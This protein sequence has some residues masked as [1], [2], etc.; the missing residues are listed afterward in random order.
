M[1]YIDD[2]R[3][4]LRA[5]KA[6][7]VIRGDKIVFDKEQL[8]L[9]LALED[10]EVEVTARIL[11]SIMD[12][13]V[14]GIRFT[15]ETYLDFKQNWGLPTLDSMLKVVK[16]EVGK[17]KIGYMFY[18][19]E[20]ST[21]LVTPYRSAQPINGKICSLSQDV[22]RVMSNSNY[23]VTMDEKIAMLDNFCARMEA[24]G[25]PPKIAAQVVRNGLLCYEKK[26]RK[27]KATGK[28]FH[29]PEEEGKLERRIGKL[30][31]RSNWF[32]PEKKKEGEESPKPYIDTA[33]T[34]RKGLNGKVSRGVGTRAPMKRSVVNRSNQEIR[35]TAPIFVQATKNGDMA[36]LLREEEEKIGRMT[37]WRFKVVE[38]GGRSLKSLLTKSNI[39]SDQ[40]C[41]RENCGACNCAEKP[42]NCRRRS[43]MYETSCLECMKNGVPGAVYVGESA[44]S[45]GERMTEHLDDAKAR[46]KDSHIFK[47]WQNQ[48]GGATTRFSFKIISFFSSPLERQVAEAIRIERTGAERILNSKGMFNRSKMVRIV[49]RDTEEETTLGDRLEQDMEEAVD[50]TEVATPKMSKKALRLARMKD[51]LNWGQNKASESVEDDNVE[52]QDSDD[53]DVV[54]FDT[55][56]EELADCFVSLIRSA[57]EDLKGVMKS[58]SKSTVKKQSSLLGWIKKST[59]EVGN[60]EKVVEGDIQNTNQK[61]ILSVGKLTDP[62]LCEDLTT[63][64]EV[65]KAED[66][67][68]EE[69]KELL[70]EEVL[71]PRV[72][73]GEEVDIPRLQIQGVGELTGLVTGEEIISNREGKRS[74]EVVVERELR[75]YVQFPFELPGLEVKRDVAGV[76]VVGDAVCRGGLVEESCK[77]VLPVCVPSLLPGLGVEEVRVEIQAEKD[78]V[79]TREEDASPDGVPLLL[80]GLGVEEVGVEVQ[81]EKVKVDVGA[82]KEAA[83]PSYLGAQGVSHRGIPPTVECEAH[84]TSS[85]QNNKTEVGRSESELYEVEPRKEKER[86]DLEQSVQGPG[87][88]VTLFPGQTKELL[89]KLMMKIVQDVVHEAVEDAEMYSMELLSGELRWLTIQD[90]ELKLSLIK[91][92]RR[93]E[94]AYFHAR[95]SHA[96]P[97][98]RMDLTMVEEER[99]S[100]E[101]L[102]MVV[103]SQGAKTMALFTRMGPGGP[104]CPGWPQGGEGPHDH[105]NGGAKEG[106]GSLDTSALHQVH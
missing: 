67:L 74:G 21:N 42:L 79:E 54:E 77:Q 88:V 60:V 94:D 33:L 76:H 78:E 47:H 56:D 39:F 75:S 40:G 66:I 90:K 84:T 91:E 24:S 6:G 27:M 52:A 37:G 93:L 68:K 61:F 15:T 13:L 71:L 101:L 104:G 97:M 96:K 8:A 38:R 99:M 85:P 53:E 12:D 51:T 7:A 81:P 30:M 95:K 102:L 62:G 50:M 83:S 82:R 105:W 58:S 11:R 106:G 22:F 16:S 10:P 29:R 69:V 49:A 1:R 48:H 2:V 46:R 80:P 103:E 72:S 73:K 43:I 35:V 4:V 87:P 55:D 98:E 44:R 14:E 45:A 23:V 18:K 32:R 5:I 92:E 86:N 17:N 34:A 63:V 20:V 9:D 3:G 26:W 64:K 25:Y 100:T 28:L 36:R 70:L 41:G 31:G 59:K 19:K 65:R 89:S 57:T